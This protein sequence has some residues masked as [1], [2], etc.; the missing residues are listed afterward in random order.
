MFSCYGVCGSGD[1]HHGS[2]F[3]FLP[4]SSCGVCSLDVCCLPAVALSPFGFSIRCFAQAC[5]WVFDVVRVKGEALV[6][7]PG[8]RHRGVGYHTFQ[9]NVRHFIGLRRETSVLCMWLQLGVCFQLGPHELSP[10]HKLVVVPSS[11]VFSAMYSGRSLWSL[12]L[13]G[14]NSRTLGRSTCDA[15]C[16]GCA[17]LCCFPLH[18]VRT[19][20]AFWHLTSCRRRFRCRCRCRP[21]W[22]AGLVTNGT[23]QT[24]SLA[25]IYLADIVILCV[26]KPFSNSV[27]QWLETLLVR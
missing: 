20:C 21:S 7:G 15:W 25:A 10:V 9:Q 8:L 16:V 5:Y 26:L 17:E 12:T 27:V 4:F 18:A 13:F 14:A 1:D 6:M 3:F 11:L 19:L 24:A 22:Y 2:I 23:V